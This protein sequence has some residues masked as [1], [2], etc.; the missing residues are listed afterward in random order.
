MSFPCIEISLPP[1]LDD[2]FSWSRGP[3]LKVEDRMALVIELSR[4]NIDNATGGPFAA[5]IFDVQSGKLLAPG[6]NMVVTGNLSVLHAE[7]VAMMIAQRIIG[8]YDL[9]SSS[10]G[11]SYELVATTEPC[12]MCLGAIPWSGIRYL[13]CGARDEDARSVGFD[14][15]VK[16][17]GWVRSMKDRGIRV[18]RDVLR[19]EAAGVLKRY[20]ES[21]GIIYGSM[22]GRLP[23]RP[24]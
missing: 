5:G 1:W 13:V 20:H 16:P 8:H 12:A 18:L 24:R 9:G 6:V 3:Y 19:S 7:I 11:G 4:L 17:P 14:E 10:M 2:Y 21:G 22:Q 15:G 23:E